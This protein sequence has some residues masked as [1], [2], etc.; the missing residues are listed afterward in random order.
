LTLRGKGWDDLIAR[1]ENVATVNG[2][3]AADKLKWIKVCLAGRAQKALQSLSDETQADYAGVKK[4]LT[5][6]FELASKREL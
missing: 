5:E 4:A 3:E 6:R 2:W 1:F